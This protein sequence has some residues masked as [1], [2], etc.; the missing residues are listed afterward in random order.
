MANQ[1]VK[2]RQ[3][4]YAAYA[5]TYI[6]VVIAVIVVVNVLADRYNKSYDAT[7]NKRYSLSEQTAKIVK[8]LKQ[9]ATITYFNQS[10]RFREGKDLLEEY[11]NLSPKVKVEYVDPDKDPQRAREAGIRNFGTAIVRIGDK[12]EEAKSITEEGITGAFIR[13]LKSNS[14]TICF[15]TGSGEHQIDDSDREGFSQFKQLLGKD[16][17]ETKTVDL[18][19]KPEVPSD[20]TTLV[21]AGPTRN[22]VQ[23][24]VDALKK[25]VEDGGRAFFMLDPPLKMGRSDIADNDALTSLLQSW[26][27]TVDK[28]LILD[29]S[30][31]GQI[32]GLGPQV[33]LVSNYS[34]QPIVSE[35]KRTATGFPLARSIQIKNGDKTNVEKLFD[36]STS[37]LATTNLSSDRISVQDPNNKKGPLTMAAAGTY[38]TGKPNSQGRFVV[39]GNSGWAANR[40]LDFNGNSDLAL[41]AVNWLASD[42]DLISIRPKAPENRRVSMTQRQF[43]AV[44]VTS[45]FILPLI[46]VVAGFGVWWKRR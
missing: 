18:L 15:V 42:E 43:N 17:Y 39:I 8:G 10:T 29:L 4:K 31:V 23:P 35:I 12:K 27:V 13:D 36:S 30:P 28:D 14:R 25:Y 22:Y 11:K 37:S 21:V 26:G 38:N 40:F 2:A 46:V 24:E 1:W 44:L 19:Q 9:D 7:A 32:F 6:L 33:A 41:N 5:A 20:C 34:S 3:T 16:D 45:Q